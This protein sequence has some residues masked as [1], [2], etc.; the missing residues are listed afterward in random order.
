M[1]TSLFSFSL[2]LPS[3][4]KRGQL[5][6]QEQTLP[7]IVPAT[8]E[9]LAENILQMEIPPRTTEEVV[10][11]VLMTTTRTSKGMPQDMEVQTE[12]TSQED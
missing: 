6:A 2:S 10:Q 5:T 11:D 9:S 1:T 4:P 3:N 7:L 8:E 12:R